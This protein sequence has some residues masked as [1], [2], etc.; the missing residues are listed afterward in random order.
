VTACKLGVT[1]GIDTLARAI[2]PVSGES[3]SLNG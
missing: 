3:Q 2:G 1:L